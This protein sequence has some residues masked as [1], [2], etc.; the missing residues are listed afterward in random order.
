MDLKLLLSIVAA[1]IPG[2]FSYT[3]LDKLNLVS[4]TE[5]HNYEKTL[6]V[7]SL[8][9]FNV[10]ASIITLLLL[11]IDLNL[12]TPKNLITIILISLSVTMILSMI[13]Y[14]LIFKLIKSLLFKLEGKLNIQSNLKTLPR[15][16]ENAPEGINDI[17]V[18]IFDVKDK[19]YISSGAIGVYSKFDAEFSLLGQHDPSEYNEVLS[20]YNTHDYKYKDFYINLDKGFCMFIFYQI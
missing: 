4:Y 19:K 1:G 11:K 16:I 20:I 7:T 8:S 12:N 14:P 13:V 17:Y 2:L 6:L 10:I 3:I 5:K 15:I 9:S 18:Y